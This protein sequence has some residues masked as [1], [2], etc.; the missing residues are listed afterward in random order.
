[1]DPDRR[2]PSPVWTSAPALT[3]PIVAVGYALLV[4]PSL[5][6]LDSGE[7]AGASFELGVSHAP[8]HPLA[9]LLGKLFCFLPI[10]DVALRVGL[11]QALCGA[12]A[13][14]VVAWLGARVAG[15]F[16]SD[17]GARRGLGTFAGLLYAA[18]YAALFQAI[19]PEVYALSAF[20]TL[21]TLAM[22]VRFT[23]TGAP[24]HLAV[25]GLTFGLGLA[26]HHYLT[27]VGAAPASLVLLLAGRPRPELRRGLAGAALAGGAALLLY[28]YLP[29]R[30]AH[31]PIFDWGHPT[32][33]SSLWWTISAQAFRRNLG[34]PHHG[35]WP[36]VAA[37]L[38]EQ[39]T[40]LAPLVAGA[41]VYLC[42]RRSPRL[43]AALLVACAA[44]VAAR[45]LISFDPGNPDAY[46]YLST[47]IAA[48]A[49]LCV[50]LPAA[51]L[52]GAP[53]ALRVPATAVLCALAIVHGAIT[54][55][56]ASL[57]RFAATRPIY[58]GLVAEVPT[59]AVLVPAYYQTTFALDYLR[60][61]EGLRPD[62][63][64]LPRHTLDHPGR[65]AALVRRD[66]RL[67]PLLDGARLSIDGL[68]ASGRPALVEY[69][70][71]LDRRLVSRAF[72]V[73]VDGDAGELQTHRF[74]AWE[75]FLRL[76]QL[77]RMGAPGPDLA[78][79]DALARRLSGGGDLLDD[80]RARCRDLAG[81]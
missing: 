7:L 51:L 44:P 33:P 39:L 14:A 25:A 5:Y 8:G 31:D 12:G 62:L 30:A 22:C 2:T 81:Q 74:A 9:M 23:E 58:E 32:T 59:G 29:L 78:H 17:G 50:P 41:G 21:L 53:V 48:F 71:D 35:D 80:L 36:L 24:R 18:S 34:A 57:V 70:V 49:L 45:M 61:V 55:R 63:S 27:I 6:W 15:H 56:G 11:A 40:P 64:Y 52:A 4:C 1:M 38:L 68:L 65:I 47:G 46:G 69:D 20:L 60:V 79:A 54:A 43:G 26:N 73:R 37:A 13:A 3:F 10:G 66:P 42:A 16:V 67:A 28:L 76:H 77:C 19:R 72:V 75:A